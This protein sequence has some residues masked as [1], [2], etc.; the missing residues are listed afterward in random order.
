MRMFQVPRQ[1]ASATASDF[2]GQLFRGCDVAGRRLTLLGSPTYAQFELFAPAAWLWR[3]RWLFVR[4][5]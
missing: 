4:L 2:R 5:E 1:F 3:M